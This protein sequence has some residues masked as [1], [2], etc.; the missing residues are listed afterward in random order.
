ML[1]KRFR[2]IGRAV[3]HVQR[4]RTIVGVFLNY[5]Y[6]DLVRRL[7]LPSALRWSFQRL[8]HQ[9]EDI[10]ALTPHERLRRAFEEL[11]PTFIKLGQ[12]LST[13]SHLLP[14]PLIDELAK[15]HDQV[16][17][18]PFPEIRAAIETE[19]KAPLSENFIL[20]DETPLGSASIA[21]VHS[22]I[23]ASG[24]RVVVKVQRPGIEKLVRVDLEIMAQI[25][26]LLE[27]HVEGWKVHRPTAVVAEFAKRLEQELDFM[28]EAAH[29]ERFAHQFAG[30]PTLHVPAV[31]RETSTR[32]VLTMER[33]EGIKASDM[34][35]L[36]AADLNR[37]E[38][39]TRIADLV[40]KQVFVHGFFHAD[41][42]PGNIHILPGNMICFLDFGMMGFLD[43]RTREVF[44]DLVTGIALRDEAAV[45]GAL[46]KL[47][48]AELDPPRP[49]LEADISEFMHQ[50]FYR[51]MGEMVFGKLVNHLFRLTGKHGL[52]MPA[53]LFTM[54][55]A[56][57]LMENLVSRL[58]PSHDLI[59]QAKPFL[60]EVHLD[61]VRP[62]RL[63]RQL[64]SF[65]GD[66]SGFLKELPL[67]IRRTLAT[68][69]GGKG[70]ITFR[71]EG[72]EP[73]DNTLER[74]SNRLSF[75]LVLAALL[76]ASSLVIHSGIPPKWH[77]VPVIG[78]VGY[79][80]SGFMGFWLLI[81]IIRH[82]RM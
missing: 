61:R 21:Q 53:D 68:L 1:F 19:L 9:P 23:L 25:A 42:H 24:R 50:N 75:A 30:E 28:A 2:Q 46:L 51:P 16:P 7:P 32:R 40:M 26:G 39:A 52:T 48:D 45:T 31:F 17:P 71:H 67:E 66:A 15:L 73:L 54:M 56:L 43:Q 64:L 55:K 29:L 6:E 38:I 41:P 78:L 22:A 74:A 59:G 35:A 4:Y 60:H 80:F 62:K 33:I 72:L 14:K 3:E 8:R 79:V 10:A 81:S 36:E 82:G 63:L 77:D 44:A 27:N 57:S 37:Q 5:G 20:V 70:K 69:K 11:G 12:L 65:G 76:I 13:R 49:G 18:I 58:A 34:D 47:S